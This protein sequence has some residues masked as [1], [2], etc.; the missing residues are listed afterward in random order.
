MTARAGGK[1]V[2]DATPDSA[3]IATARQN[4]QAF[5]ALYQRYVHRVYRYALARL[6]HA[7]EAADA[8]QQT[9]LRAWRSLDQYRAEH[10]FAAW[11]FGIARLVTST[12]R[13]RQLAPVSWDDVPEDDHPFAQTGNPEVVALLHETHTHIQRLL[14]RLDTEKQELL[15]LYRDDDLSLAEIAAILGRNPE[16][17]RKQIARILKT[18]RE[19]YHATNH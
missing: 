19:Q 2:N 8:T 16:A 14:R 5:D 9:F 3:L 18:L 15:A 7:E 12:M 6:H 10:S 11:L 17:V 13:C 4:P 1:R